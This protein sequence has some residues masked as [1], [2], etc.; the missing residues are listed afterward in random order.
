MRIGNTMTEPA[1]TTA[2]AGAAGWKLI[3]GAAG[4]AWIGA[5]L[6]TAV[7]MML[8]RPR[9]AREWAVG[10]IATLVCSLCGGAFVL[11]KFGLLQNLPADT[12]DPV[13]NQAQFFA[14]F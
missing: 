13:G 3:G 2:A 8:K 9:D 6:A 10:L 5:A 12:P 14:L 1:S 7:V 11:L 4:A